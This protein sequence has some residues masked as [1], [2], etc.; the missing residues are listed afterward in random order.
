MAVCPVP[1]ALPELESS[2]CSPGNRD[3]G[4]PSCPPPWESTVRKKKGE[5]FFSGHQQ[6]LS[7][8]QDL[9]RDLQPHVPFQQLQNSQGLS[10]PASPSYLLFL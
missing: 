8:C 10:L 1:L 9:N 2:V 6:T 7:H 3:Q 4:Q 5:H